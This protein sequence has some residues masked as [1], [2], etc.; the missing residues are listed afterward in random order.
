MTGTVG[1]TPALP[2]LSGRRLLH[3]Q[4]THMVLERAEAARGRGR[5]R[6][7]AKMV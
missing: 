6:L 4:I 2:E 7:T 5:H 1:I 3:C